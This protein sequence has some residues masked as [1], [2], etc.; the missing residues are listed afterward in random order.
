MQVLKS[1]DRQCVLW[2]E[3]S[4]ERH[5]VA[6]EDLHFHM[7]F[8][9]LVLD[10]KSTWIKE[11][12]KKSVWREKSSNSLFVF[13]G[14]DLNNDS[15]WQHELQ[16]DRALHCWP[17]PGLSLRRS[18]A[19]LHVWEYRVAQLP[20]REAL[21]YFDLRQARKVLLCWDRP[22]GDADT[23]WKKEGRKFSDSWQ[24]LLRRHNAAGD[25]VMSCQRPGHSLL[26]VSQSALMILLCS[27]SL[28]DAVVQEAAK[29]LLHGILTKLLHDDFCNS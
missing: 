14:D 17:C 13:S 12:L 20:T 23:D 5:K 16:E 18:D 19:F 15:R 29:Q 28:H 8:G 4:G 2:H 25:H 6:S 10:G 26:L 9:F 27:W 7:G 1:R 11:Y 22:D 3:L 24:P 21:L